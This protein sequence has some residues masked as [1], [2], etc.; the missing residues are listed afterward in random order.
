MRKTVAA[1]LPIGLIFSLVSLACSNPITG[2]L[3]T[4]TAMM[5]TATATLFTATPTDSPTPTPTATP[6]ATLTPSPTPLFRNHESCGSPSSDISYLLPETWDLSTVESTDCSALFG[7]KMSNGWRVAVLFYV[8]S[9]TRTLSAIA[10]SIVSNMENEKTDFRYTNSSRD[11][12]E[13]DSGLDAEK[14][15]GVLTQDGDR[16][17][18]TI[19][20]FKRGSRFIIAEYTRLEDEFEVLDAEVDLIMRSV[21]LE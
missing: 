19:Y 10:A 15:I 14:I 7:P 8:H 20:V 16:Y 9:D 5:R 11:S 17:A 3:S 12:F 6:T 13:T 2:F 18:D 4:R 21:E 1:L